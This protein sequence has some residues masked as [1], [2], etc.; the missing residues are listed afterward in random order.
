MQPRHLEIPL[1]ADVALP[2]A[3]NGQLLPGRIED[4]QPLGPGRV[5]KHDERDPRRSPPSRSFRSAGVSA[6]RLTIQHKPDVSLP[7]WSVYRW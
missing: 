4:D 3:P 2:G 6:T 1:E 7:G 5:A